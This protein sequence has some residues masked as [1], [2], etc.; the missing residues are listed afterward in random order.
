MSAK[1][2]ETKSFPSGIDHEQPTG[3]RSAFS[4]GEDQANFLTLDRGDYGRGIT[5]AP[6]ISGD[7]SSGTVLGVEADYAGVVLPAK[8]QDNLTLKNQRVGP[9]AKKIIGNVELLLKISRPNQ[10]SGFKFQ[11]SQPSGHAMGIDES[12]IDHRACSGTA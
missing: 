1:G 11:A 7:P 9:F 12:G 6:L 3:R 10:F 5:R 2:S 8:I 4:S